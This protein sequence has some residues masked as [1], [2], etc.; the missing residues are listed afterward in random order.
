MKLKA[1]LQR[2]KNILL[3][4]LLFYIQIKK[5]EEFVGVQIFERKSKQIMIIKVGCKIA[6]Q[7]YKVLD[8]VNN[9]HKIANFHKNYNKV[10]I[11]NRCISN[12]MHVYN[13]KDTNTNQKKIPNI[14]ISIVEEKQIY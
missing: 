10:T 8:E 7:A 6:N 1:L 3:V 2:L 9:L 14:S 12:L 13:A 4:N 5:F 11:S